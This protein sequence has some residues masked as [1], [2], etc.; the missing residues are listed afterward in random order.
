MKTLTGYFF[1]LLACAPINAAL[2]CSCQIPTLE[3]EFLQSEQVFKAQLTQATKKKK[4]FP[5]I[6]GIFILEASYKGSAPETITLTT[7]IGG[8]DCGMPFTL[9]KSYFIFKSG[10][11]AVSNCSNTVVSDYRTR[12]SY[13]KQLLK[14]QQ[15]HEDNP[16]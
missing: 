16:K 10:N 5:Y 9:G 6:E 7:G 4:D 8:G 3:N 15:M 2:A 12:D 1:L 14:L 11:N 13:P